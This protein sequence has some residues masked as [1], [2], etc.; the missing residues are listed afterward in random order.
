MQEAST[1]E[2]WK[3]VPT[4]EKYYEVSTIGR[5]HSFT[6]GKMLSPDGRC[7]CLQAESRKESYMVPVLMACAFLGLDITDPYRHRV[8]FK[9]ENPL[10]I[11]L[12]NLYIEDT[13][14]LE[15]EEW[16]P[17]KEISGSVLKDHYYVSNMGRVKREQHKL[18]WMNHGK[19]STKYCPE[20]MI[21]QVKNKAGYF[22]CPMTHFN[23]KDLTI[24]VHRLVATAF[25]PND[26]PEHKI[27]VNHINGK[28]FDNRAENL[29]WVTPSENAVHAIKTGLKKHPHKVLRYPVIHLETNQYYNSVSNVD[30][31]M[32]RRLG[33]TAERLKFNEPVKDSEGN[34]WTLRI[35]KD[36]YMKVGT[37]GQHCTIDEIPG[38]EFISLGEAS[39]A[40]GRWDGYISDALK[41]GGIIR[42]KAGRIMHVNLIGG[43]PVVGANEVYKAKKE[44]ELVP[45][46]KE[47]VKSNNVSTR[48]VK[49]VE[50]GHVYASLAAASRAMG[51]K[52]G[53]ISDCIAFQRDCIDANGNKWTLE[54]LDQPV[55]IHYRKN[56]CY[57]DELVG[58]E[59]NNYTEASE[60]IG[61][62]GSYI[63]GRISSNKPIL[64][65]EG[66]EM[67]LHILPN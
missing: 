44:A 23:G 43:A 62:E 65:K 45:K 47:R 58:Q 50:T 60:A 36:T 55:K 41:R 39:A 49:H 15:G 24:Q 27:Q 52:D 19:L 48:S 57:F 16:R 25:C 46:A 61:R 5:V 31:A 40:I 11:I 64:N 42:N 32:G 67:H 37:E 1:N 14:S 54:F 17:I 53:Y 51:K 12:S 22:S 4:F 9:D 59:F 33:Y 2:R 29:E 66:K 7:V 8:L 21:S 63:L 18:T 6:S 30:R 28:P 13:S 26:D 35:L 34:I 3:P 20:V 10:N 38:R 56:P